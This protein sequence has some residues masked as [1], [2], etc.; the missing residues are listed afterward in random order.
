VTSN[1]NIRNKRD[2]RSSKPDRILAFALDAALSAWI[3]EELSGLGLALQHARSVRE[4]VAALVEDPPPRPQIMVADLDAMTPADV[5]QL[6]AVR[7]RGWF[8]AIIAIGN[9]A[10]VLQTSLNIDRVLARPLGSEVLRKA[11]NRIGLDR[12]TTKLRK[13]TPP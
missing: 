8:G 4:A 13:I 5:L 1:A 10:D 9:V 7:E 12:P 3:E 2:A 11:V 6:H